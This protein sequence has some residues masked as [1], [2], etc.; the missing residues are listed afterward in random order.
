MKVSGLWHMQKS[1]QIDLP[2]R[3]REQIHPAHYIGYALF[4]IIHDHGQLICKR[5]IGAA[6]DEIAG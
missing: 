6:Q 4:G 3:R 2:R 1:L 5:A